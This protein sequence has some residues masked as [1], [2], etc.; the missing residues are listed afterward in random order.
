MVTAVQQQATATSPPTEVWWSPATR[1]GF[2]FLFSY[3]FLY[4]TPGA[5][6]SLGSHEVVSSYHAIFAALWRPV[7]PWVG[8]HILGVKEAL[9]EFPNG[10]GDQLYDYVLI[11]CLLGTAALATALWTL[12]DGKRTNYQ[13]LYLWLRL[14]LRLFL[15]SVM[16]LYGSSKLFPMQF[17]DIP[18]G[19]LSDPLGHLSPLGL[20]W[21]FMGYSRLYTIFGGIGEM[22]GGLLLI[23][24]RFTTLGALVSL[25]VLSNVLMLNLSYDVPRKI[26]T[27]HLMLIAVLLTLPDIKRLTNVFILNRATEPIPDA[28]FFKDQLLNRGVLVLQYL[29]GLV[30]L[31]IALQVSYHMAIPIQAKIAPPLRGV[32]S[33]DE[34][35]TNGV[36]RPPLVTDGK[37]WYHVVFESPTFMTIQP[38]DGPLQLYLLQLDA[39]G[40]TLTLS[41]VPGEPSR[42]V[43]FTLETETNGRILMAGEMDGQT[44]KATLHRVDL[45]DPSRFLLINRGFHW[46]TP[47]PR[48]R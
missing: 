45:S 9:V 44:V 18:L 23:V 33:V 41:N 14:V 4:L 1:I 46:V 17:A 37:R 40:K 21:T 3:F 27:I 19:R 5:V 35:A 39:G 36:A 13:Q 47:T 12:L 24:P 22:L 28:P 25:G 34:F 2:R 32:W 30:T 8:A 7:V 16:M 6:G 43:T 48:W 26:F 42:K 10:S 38:M 15:A 29:Y 20:L 31:A 11:V